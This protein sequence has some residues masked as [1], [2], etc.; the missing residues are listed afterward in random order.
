MICPPLHSKVKGHPLPSAT[1]LPPVL[2]SRMPRQPFPCLH[3]S[4][5]SCSS[6]C[7][8]AFCRRAHRQAGYPSLLAEK[9]F[10]L[11]LAGCNRR[12]IVATNFS[13]KGI[14]VLFKQTIKIS[15]NADVRTV[16]QRLKTPALQDLGM[17]F[18]EN[19]SAAAEFLHLLC[20]CDSR[21][22]L[23]RNNYVIFS[24]K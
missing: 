1:L 12:V 16:K 17:L 23:Y 2:T 22:G 7:H 19:M 11:L 6:Q 10:Q 18:P 13:M 15:S 9:D 5:R 24:V 20:L 3:W 8:H 4:H 14:I 21:K